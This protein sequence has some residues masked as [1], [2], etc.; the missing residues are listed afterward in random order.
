MGPRPVRDSAM[1]TESR[2]N[3]DPGGYDRTM[4]DTAATDRTRFLRTLRQVRSFDPAPVAPEVLDDILEVARWTGSSQNQQE[5]QLIVVTD[6]GTL[7]QLSEASPSAGHI[8]AAP[9][10]VVVVMP[11]ERRIT[12][13]FDEG[14]IAER[15]MLAATAHGLGCGMAWLVAGEAAVKELLRVP[16]EHKVRTAIAIGT[17]NATGRKR[18]AARGTARRPVSE[19]VH[20]ERWGA[21]RT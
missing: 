20:Y 6:P 7:R 18:K 13:A 11:G 16:S 2:R 19:T 10:A 14:R 3:T 4:T 12:D 1:R 15:I 9:L 17:P 5:W 8:A 21:R